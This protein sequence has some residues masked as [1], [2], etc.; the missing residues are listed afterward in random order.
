MKRVQRKRTKG[1]KMPENAKYVGRPTKWGNPFRVEELG[2]EEA[3][4]RYKECILNNAMCYAYI[5]DETEASIQFDR[6][7]WMAE[8]LE[9]LR[10]LDLA[11]FCSLSSPCHADALIELLT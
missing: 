1:W 3:V 4:K 6:F 11:C 5:D 9:Q 2:A 7:K 8:N 10:G